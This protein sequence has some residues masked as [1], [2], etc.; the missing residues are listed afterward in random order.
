MFKRAARDA[1]ARGIVSAEGVAD[2]TDDA[3]MGLLSGDKGSALALAIRSRRLYKRALDLSAGEVTAEP[4]GWITDD[5]D[6]AQRVEDALALEL[7]LGAGELLLDYPAREDM[8]SVDLPLRLRD[9]TVERL[10]PE[11]RA[12][13]LGLPRIAGE[14][15]ASARRLRVFTAKPPRA[16]LENV[17]T[18][19]EMSAEDIRARLHSE[20]AL[21]FAT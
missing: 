10:T 4:Q 14:L 8:L 7:G 3:L 2:L 1:V 15:Y 20:K 21:L 16:S 17:P 6:L 19:L 13:H 5:P 11:G 9:G 18:L 12:G